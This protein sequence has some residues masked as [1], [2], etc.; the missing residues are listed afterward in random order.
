MLDQLSNISVRSP[1]GSVVVE[2]VS[3]R[4]VDRRDSKA[5]SARLRQGV[6]ASGLNFGRCIGLASVEQSPL[7]AAKLQCCL[8]VPGSNVGVTY[9]SCSSGC[10]EPLPLKTTVAGLPHNEHT[11]SSG[12][13][14]SS[15][16]QRQENK[17]STFSL[18]KSPALEAVRR[19]CC[20]DIATD[21]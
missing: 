17:A 19:I 1:R 5:L 13:N 8:N 9:D 12:S 21:D 2:R 7:S 11:G 18:I 10:T 20:G 14:Q 15:E 3:R 6:L 4:G 16:P